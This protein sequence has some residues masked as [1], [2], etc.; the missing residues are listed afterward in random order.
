MKKFLFAALIASLGSASAF[1]ADL[2]A[3]LYTKAP[4]AP[5][6]INWTGFYVGGNLGYGW[7]NGDTSFSP[8]PDPIAFALKPTTLAPDSKGIIGGAQ[9][10]YNW[11]FNSLV[12]GLEAD[13]QGSG[14]KGSVTQPSF[15]FG[16]QLITGA[17]DLLTSEKL[18][19]FGTVR[20]RVGIT[21]TPE[22]LLY[23]TGGLAYGHAEY[24][25]QTH[26]PAV[27]FPASFSKTK[28]GWTAGGGAE[29]AFARSWSAK[30]EY[31][32]LDLGDES[33]VAT[34]NVGFEEFNVGYTWKTRE[35]IV[36]AGLNYHF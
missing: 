30:V 26:F 35:N 23:V 29:W 6:P 11:Q 7:G 19:W 9:I 18:S 14:I 32:Y 16:D 4:F 25:A 21:T 34:P 8:L 27:D 20:G 31:L 13:I 1:A 33:V 10:G 24:A 5:A 28:A 36:R 17:G 12:A 3:R 2:P 22:L 15:I